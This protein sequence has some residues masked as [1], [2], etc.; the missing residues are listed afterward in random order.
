MRCL[1]VCTLAALSL[2]GCSNYGD[3]D[4]G[5]WAE[6]IVDGTRSSGDYPAV[7]LVLNRAGGMCSGSLIAPRV[8]LTAKHCVQGEGDAAPTPPGF[9]VVGVGDSLNGLT[10]SFSVQQVR[11]T[12]GSY[13]S[14]LR[15]LTGI[16]VA[17]LTLTRGATIEPL[18]VYRT[19][20]RELIGDEVLSVGFGQTPA[21][22]SGVKYFVN[23]RVNGTNG[24]VLISGPTI[25]QGDS[26]GPL[27][28]L[29]GQV[30]GVASWGSG[31]C[32]SGIN[33][34]NNVFSF[35]DLIDEAVAESGACLNDGPEVCDSYDNDCDDGVDEGCSEVGEAC[36]S[37]DTCVGGPEVG[38][39]CQDTSM[40]RL[41]TVVCDALRPS[42]SCGPGLF[43]EVSAGCEGLCLPGSAG[44]AGNGEACVTD[45]DCLSLRCLDPGDGMMRCLTP[46]QGDTGRCLAGEACA[47]L[48]GVCGG[49]VDERILNALR[50]LGESC[51]GDDD[52]LSGQCL[53]EVEGAGY[54]SRPCETDSSCGEGFHCRMEGVPA[55]VRGN[56]EGIGTPC[57]TNSDC[58]DGGFCATQN[59]VSWCTDFCPP[60]ECPAGY[61]CVDVGG[62]IG[63]CAPELG[64]MGADCQSA[65]DCLSGLCA[66]TEDGTICTRICGPDSPCGP[67][68]ECERSADG[69]GASCV[70]RRA[71]VPASSSGCSLQAADSSS[72][73]GSFGLLFVLAALLVRARRGRS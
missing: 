71:V 68:F 53:F 70:P 30:F 12:P 44:S 28:T 33:G 8:V 48:P 63:L 32:G 58:H 15:G 31:G 18:Q 23:T 42:A 51:D 67:G 73:V 22:G 64:V 2:I 20:P 6:P 47:A 27:M 49:C 13:G 37:S 69:T 36:T 40:G 17:V 29:D 4:I 16:D 61:A 62:D 38:P 41:C 56:R 59:G 39:T 7:V 65:E 72:P 45:T 52:C 25:C 34:F 3:P 60:V 1:F 14:G 57:Q 66:E 35:L 9:F 55:C 54:C 24:N 5:G 11:T 43:C 19:N 26:G 10:Q 21:G 46:C 50:G